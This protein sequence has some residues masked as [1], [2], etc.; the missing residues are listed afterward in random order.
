MTDGGIGRVSLAMRLTTPIERTGYVP[1]FAQARFPFGIHQ[2]EIEGR[3]EERALRKKYLKWDMPCRDLMLRPRSPGWK[4]TPSITIPII[5]LWAGVKRAGIPHG[6]IRSI[7]PSA[8]EALPG[9]VAVLTAKHVPG[10]NRQGIVHKDQPV[11]ADEQV[12]H[13]GDPVALV[14]AETREVLK[15]AVRLI[16]V[17]LEPLPAVFDPVDALQPEAPRLHETGNLL[18]Q[19]NIK[20]GSGADALEECDVVVEGEFQVPFQE[21]AFLETENGVRGRRRTAGS[22]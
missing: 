22:P 16:R 7:D 14:L 20:S 8:A 9:V 12:R 15:E 3:N 10:T 5:F 18:L 1:S 6:R 21:H 17:D 2:L 11:L 19:A 13:R 4:D